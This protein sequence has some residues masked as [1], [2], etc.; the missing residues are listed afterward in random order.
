[1]IHFALPL[2]QSIK[3]YQIAGSLES[4][5]YLQ[6]SGKLFNAYLISSLQYLLLQCNTDIQNAAK[7]AYFFS[8]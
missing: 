4:S 8:L 1:M 6:Y 3:V 7:K 2:L 5:H